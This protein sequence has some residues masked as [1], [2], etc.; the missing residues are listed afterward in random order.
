MVVKNILVNVINLEVWY[1]I[2][3][4]VN[5]AASILTNIATVGGEF[6]LKGIW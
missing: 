5:L 6:P 3:C 2:P 4:V 1:T